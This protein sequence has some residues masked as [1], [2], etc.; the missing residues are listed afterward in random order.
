[1]RKS[2]LWLILIGANRKGDRWN[3]RHSRGLAAFGGQT[4][5]SGVASEF[6]L[7]LI[8]FHEAGRG[9][10][11]QPNEARGAKLAKPSSLLPMR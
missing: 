3:E 1:M 9:H 10:A 8:L 11:E 7:W 6:G 4:G 2:L 5:I